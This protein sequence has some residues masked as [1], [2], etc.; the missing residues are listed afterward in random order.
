MKA[1][2]KEIYRIQKE[3]K[4]LGGINSLLGWDQRTYM[5][6]DGCFKDRAE[7][8]SV[9]SRITHKKFISPSFQKL[10]MIIYFSFV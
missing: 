4:M 2:L 5:P 8:I 9:I 1:E 10:I 7:Q 6:Q 3:L